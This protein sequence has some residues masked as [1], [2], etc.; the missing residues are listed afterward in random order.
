LLTLEELEKWEREGYVRLGQVAST[1]QLAAL[2]RRI[3]EAMLGRVPNE[4]IWFQLDTE[5]G[6]YGDLKFGDG[7]WSIPTLNYRKIERLERDPVFLDY[8]RHPVFRDLTRQLIGEEVSIYRAM[9]MNK[10]AGRGT[11]LPYHQDGGTQWGLSQ[12]PWVTVWTALDDATVAS[13]CMQVIPG[14]HRLGLLSDR[15]HTITPEQQA[16]HAKDE[17]SIFLEACQG[18]AILLHNLLLHRSGVN[19]TGKP[20]RA[21]SVC[22]MDAA[23][24]YVGEAGRTF[25]QVFRPGLE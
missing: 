2:Q 19:P 11:H 21:F 3:D 13:G 4:E 1:D 8:I 10:P 17:D 25:T 20:R 18:E 24:R 14:S 9:F 16:R 22:Y 5:T 7:S 12:D 6:E 23:T 15:G